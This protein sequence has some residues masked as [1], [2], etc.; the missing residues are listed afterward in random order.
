[1][2]IAIFVV[3]VFIGQLYYLVKKYTKHVDNTVYLRSNYDL[4]CV[5]LYETSISFQN[6]FQC[7]DQQTSCL[8]D[9]LAS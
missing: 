7:Y 2:Y 6:F 1:M 4:T 3:A 5:I 8:V 9:A